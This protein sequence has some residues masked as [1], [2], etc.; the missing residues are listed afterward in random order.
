MIIPA[1][2]FRKHMT[3]TVVAKRAAGI[4]DRRSFIVGTVCYP[5]RVRASTR[6][7]ASP[8]DRSPSAGACV[9]SVIPRQAVE[10][11]EGGVTPI[12]AIRHTFFGTP[13]S[14]ALGWHCPG[15]PNRRDCRPHQTFR[16]RMRQPASLTTGYRSSSCTIP[17]NR[18][19]DGN[20][21]NRSS[22]KTAV[23]SEYCAA[24]RVPDI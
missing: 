16:R 17:D 22:P 1:R 24:L 6:R 4:V 2:G 23:L 9:P 8:A 11:D 19:P 15:R 10:P 14:T 20:G 18:P 5:A 3:K 13:G 12:W 21:P 7:P